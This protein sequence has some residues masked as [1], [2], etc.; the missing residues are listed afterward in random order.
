MIAAA[1][2]KT[3]PWWQS[4]AF[5]WFDVAVVLMLLLGL[6]RGRKHGMSKEFLPASQWVVIVAAAGFGHAGLADWLL[7]SEFVKS[8]FGRNFTDRTEV[9]ISSY[10]LIAF[11]VFFVFVLLRRRYGPK[12][13]GSGMF[14]SGEYYLGMISGTLRFACMLVAAL[15]LLNAPFYTAADLQ[16][17][18]A[19]NN[20]WYGGGMKNFEGDFIPSVDELQVSVF[21]QS[22]LGP[23][24]KNN[25][26]MLLINTLPAGADKKKLPSP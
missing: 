15:A 20:R 7:H 18:R 13:T 17:Q 14:G 11:V 9:F 10:L 3:T 24:L 6:W 8:M 22:L 4:L 12:L 5:N 2:L 21:K 26:G 19:Y 1:V 23:F 25:L 16:V